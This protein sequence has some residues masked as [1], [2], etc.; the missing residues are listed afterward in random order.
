[1]STLEQLDY[2]RASRAEG[3]TRCDLHKGR[4]CL[5]FGSGGVNPAIVII[6]EAP[7][8]E[9]NR[10]GEPFSGPAG[11]LLDGFLRRVGIDRADV[12][13]LNMVKCRPPENR[14]PTDAELE[15]CAP[16]LHLQL[17]LL[18]PRVILAVGGV[19]GRYLAGA[20][21]DALVG[22]LRSQ[23]WLYRNEVTK[24]TA[25][26]VVTYHPSYILRK[27]DDKPT[28]KKVARKVIA[29]LGKVLRLAAG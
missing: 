5:V 11:Q 26:L 18:Q 14:D 12:Y 3:C 17:A 10:T 13:I 24:V 15:A 27:Q 7:G 16:F 9:E 8:D 29:D 19:A 1:M 21:D 6:G 20:P 4:N 28:A 2:L 23:D 25:P 22:Y